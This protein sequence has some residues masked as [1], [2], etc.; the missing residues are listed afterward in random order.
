MNQH[1]ELM[2]LLRSS[3]TVAGAVWAVVALLLLW[4]AWRAAKRR[5]IRVHKRYMIIVAAVAAVSLEAWLMSLR[6]PQILPEI[7]EG[8][9]GWVRLVNYISI[10]PLVGATLMI[11]ARWRESRPTELLGHFNTHHRTYG[12]AFI[13]LWCFSYIASLVNTLLLL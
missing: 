1:E 3:A 7:P 2:A 13:L 8:M 4:L 10:I 12:Q 5:D 11:L 9:V 6:Y